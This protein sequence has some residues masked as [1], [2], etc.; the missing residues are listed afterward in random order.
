MN[1]RL[2]LERISAV[3][4]GFWGLLAGTMLLAFLFKTDVTDR[5]EMAGMG[6][7]GLVGA[8]LAH[9]LTCWVIGGFFT[10]RT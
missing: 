2:G 7:A 1:I 6:A 3:W 8:Y 5:W 4:W 10:V 9:R